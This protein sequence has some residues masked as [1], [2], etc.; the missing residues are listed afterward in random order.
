MAENG[1]GISFAG[2]RPAF[3]RWRQLFFLVRRISA[4]AKQAGALPAISFKVLLLYGSRSREYRSRNFVFDERFRCGRLT[5]GY[6]V[7][8]GGAEVLLTVRKVRDGVFCAVP[9]D[10]KRIL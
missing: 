1:A 10:L 9:D 6:G 5:A 4:D 3:S 2:V 8:S 7:C